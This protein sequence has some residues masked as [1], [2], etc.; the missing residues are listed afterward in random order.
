MR[1]TI[2]TDNDTITFGDGLQFGLKFIH[3]FL[4]SPKGTIVEFLGP[5]DSGPVTIKTHEPGSTVEPPVD[6]TELLKNA[7]KS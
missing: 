7:T 3:T 4:K 2:D 1:F 5:T 6:V